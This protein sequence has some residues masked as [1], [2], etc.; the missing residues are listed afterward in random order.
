ML[1]KSLET[2]IV[3]L[4]T[5][6]VR[7]PTDSDCKLEPVFAKSE[8]FPQILYPIVFLLQDIFAAYSRSKNKDIK[9]YEFC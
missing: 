7:Q 2:S 1:D 4:Y 5:G 3:P 8:Y 9:N 6:T